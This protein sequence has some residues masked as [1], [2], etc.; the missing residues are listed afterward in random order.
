MSGGFG[1]GGFGGMPF[2]GLGGGGG[3]GGPTFAMVAVAPVAE[4]RLRLTYSSAVYFSGIGDPQDA[5]V[6]TKYSVA[7][8]PSS[9]G[10]DGA[11]ARA[12]SV[13]AAVLSPA[14]EVGVLYG[15][16]IDLLLD[17]ALSPHPASYTAT[18]N[19]VWNSTL[20]A[21][22][23]DTLPFLGVHM[24]IAQPVVNEPRRTRDFAYPPLAVANDQGGLITS[25]SNAVASPVGTYRT[26]GRGDY[27]YDEGL[28]GLKKRIFRRLVTRPGGFAHLGLAYGVGVP[29]MLKKLATPMIVQQLI[30]EAEKQIAQEPDV[31]KVR[32]TATVDAAHN[33]VRFTVLV[34]MVSGQALSVPAAFP[35]AA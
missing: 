34:R 12:V 28:V 31:A 25:S 33:L 16:C 19:G 5:A 26:N 15:W 32:V 22:D 29:Q 18:S 13:V 35:M 23:P 27:A 10:L 1:G 11:P 7:A 6:T 30:S 21:V 17:R 4:N 2:G 24:E 9:T 8:D 14:I 3:G 20:T